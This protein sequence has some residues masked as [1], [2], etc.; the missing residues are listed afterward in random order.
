MDIA[1]RIVPADARV[2]AFT[3]NISAARNISLTNTIAIE[4]GSSAED[5]LGLLE[6]SDPLARGSIG[7][8]IMPISWPE[9]GIIRLIPAN[10]VTFTVNK[11]SPAT[12]VANQIVAEQNWTLIGHNATIRDYVDILNVSGVWN[13]IGGKNYV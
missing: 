5:F 2:E 1:T 11:A 4:S 12:A 9:K 6:V 8:V 3:Y 7:A 10:G 13:V